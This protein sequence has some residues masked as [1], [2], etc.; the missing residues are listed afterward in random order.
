MIMDIETLR[1]K[2]NASP[3]RS[4]WRRAVRTYA[5]EL[6]EDFPETEWDG[7]PADHK[8][9][10]NG[11]SDW[12]QYSEGGCALIYDAD[13]AERVAPP[14]R[15]PRDHREGWLHVQARALFQAEGLITRCGRGA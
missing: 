12:L 5:L 3:A 9:L 7:S 2:I 14:S 11:A 10:L 1:D 13:I 6:L 15:R 8:A 4:T